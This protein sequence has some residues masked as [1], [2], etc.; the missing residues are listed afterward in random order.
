MTQTLTGTVELHDP[1]LRRFGRIMRAVGIVGVLA[2]IAAIAAGLWLVQDLDV[3]LGRSLRLTTE[4]L[5]A[6][7]S[8]LTVAVDTVEVVGSGLANAEQTSRGLDATLVDGA[9]L[10]D[11]TGRMLRGDVASSLES[12]ERT[13]PALIQVGGTM[14]STLRALAQLPVGVEYDPEEPFDETLRALQNDL[15]GLPEDLRTQADTV[16]DAGDNLRLVGRQGADIATSIADV[17]TSLTEASD[18]LGDYRATAGEARDLMAQTSDDLDRRLLV[19]RILIVVL[20]VV[21]CAGQA[22]P[23]YLGHRLAEAR[24]TVAQVDDDGTRAELR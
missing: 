1:A 17:R 22:L 19:V 24:A 7:D 23:L 3:L 18:V 13:M 16:D 6:V 10:L 15:D 4:S 20:G 2:G 8:S 9:D 11:E 14:D 5:T 12:V 21:F